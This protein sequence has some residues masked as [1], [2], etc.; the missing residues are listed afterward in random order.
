MI[1]RT[2]RCTKL[3]TVSFCQRDFFYNWA[4]FITR[5]ATSI[6]QVWRQWFPLQLSSALKQNHNRDKL[7]VAISNVMFSSIF[8][9]ILYDYLVLV[10]TLL[11][12]N[13]FFLK[14]II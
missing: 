11:M 13:K 9:R 10:W 8:V 3:I 6:A 1:T 5:N 4:H 7:T 2:Y 14:L 12:I